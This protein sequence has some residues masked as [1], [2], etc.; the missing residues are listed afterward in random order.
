ME[1]RKHGHGGGGDGNDTVGFTALPFSFP[2]PVASSSTPSPA[3]ATTPAATQ[4]IITPTSSGINTV[5]P[6]AVPPSPDV[7]SASPQPQSPGPQFSSATVDNLPQS[8]SRPQ[9][10]TPSSSPPA[11]SNSF[12]PTPGSQYFL[13]FQTPS[14]TTVCSSLDLLWTFAGHDLFTMTL[15]IEPQ[16][17]SSQMTTQQIPTSARVLST[18]VAVM[19]SR[20]T[21]SPVIADSGWYIANSF[22]NKNSTGVMMRSSPFF[23]APPMND[24]CLQS[25]SNNS[26]S[27]NHLHQS[28]PSDGTII[29]LSLGITAGVTLLLA[30]FLYPRLWRKELPS[31]DRNRPYLLY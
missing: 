23:I 8:S 24:S 7:S 20:Y 1:K 13:Q 28:R 26:S 5:Q 16:N 15:Y 3:V 11:T 10:A 21:W 6:S 14:N 30:A 2:S 12:P 22:D 17:V 4:V 29:G 18:D 19:D 27:S 9:S 31:H 25:T